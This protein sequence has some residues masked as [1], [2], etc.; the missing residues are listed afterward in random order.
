MKIK[1]G[2]INALSLFSHPLILKVRC[3]Y[4]QTR[5]LFYRKYALLLLVIALHRCVVHTTLD[6]SVFGRRGLDGQEGT[7]TPPR[8]SIAFHAMQLRDTDKCAF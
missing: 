3:M 1:D 6:F 8:S 7:A 5:L 4:L 2:V